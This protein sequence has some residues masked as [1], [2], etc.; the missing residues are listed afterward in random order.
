MWVATQTR[1]TNDYDHKTHLVHAFNRYPNTAVK[2]Y[3]QDY[4]Q[5]VDDDIFALCELLQWI[6]RSA[7]RK[8]EPI[9]LC[10][11]STRMR[12]LFDKWLNE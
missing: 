9:T 10:I 3:L 4:G 1:A 2:S 12:K 11:V 7:I 5:I 8:G 6:W